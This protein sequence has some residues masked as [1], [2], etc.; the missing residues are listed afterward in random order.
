MGY[1]HLWKTHETKHDLGISEFGAPVSFGGANPTGSPFGSVIKR[2]PL[3]APGR[4]C[5][6]RLA[7]VEWWLGH[8]PNIFQTKK[9]Y[10]TAMKTLVNDQKHA[11]IEHSERQ[12]F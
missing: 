1:P 5:G 3:T 8:V 4:P 2:T 7:M 11:W 6:G 10:P 12:L 9:L